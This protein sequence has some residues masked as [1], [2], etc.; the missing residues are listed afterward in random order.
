MNYKPESRKVAH[1]IFII[2]ECDDYGGGGGIG[3]PETQGGSTIRNPP[4]RPLHQYVYWARF[5]A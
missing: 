4:P 1:F 3:R 2:E 5:L